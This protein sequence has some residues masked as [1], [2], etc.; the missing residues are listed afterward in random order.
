MAASGPLSEAGLWFRAARLLFAFD[1]G[2][3]ARIV[4]VK[5]QAV[6]SHHSHRSP[7][8]WNE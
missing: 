3:V 4:A 8:S 1:V 2:M 6:L 5:V 7:A